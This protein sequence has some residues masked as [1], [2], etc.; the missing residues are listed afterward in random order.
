M[1]IYDPIIINK[2]L[3]SNSFLNDN[4][5]FSTTT[6]LSKEK[7]IMI[8]SIRWLNSCI[9]HPLQYLHQNDQKK[10]KRR[11]KKEKQIEFLG[12]ILSKILEHENSHVSMSQCYLATAVLT[13]TIKEKDK[14]FNHRTEC[15]NLIMCMKKKGNHLNQETWYFP[16]S[17][18]NNAG[19]STKYQ[20]HRLILN[21]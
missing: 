19:T 6:S 10:K 4:S 5:I 17:E 11:K 14:M 9:L 8:H 15:W 13:K 16:Q 2:S 18:T 21:A 7:N 20:Q 12:S 3:K 1:Y